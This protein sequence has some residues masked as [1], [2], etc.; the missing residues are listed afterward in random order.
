MSVEHSKIKDFSI[1]LFLAAIYSAIESAVVHIDVDVQQKLVEQYLLK[2]ISTTDQYLLENLYNHV[3]DAYDLFILSCVGFFFI[4]PWILA[5]ERDA[6]SG[7]DH[8][9]IKVRNIL[10]GI[11]LASLAAIAIDVETVQLVIKSGTADPKDILAGF[12]GIAAGF[13]V[14]NPLRHLA[15]LLHP[16]REYFRD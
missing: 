7:K 11:L 5:S 2:T 3:G 12:F 1:S 8:E 16:K 14:M 6:M 9:M 4:Q 15:H 13:A 10:I